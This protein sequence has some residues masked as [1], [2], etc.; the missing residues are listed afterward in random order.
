M[1]IIISIRFFEDV[2]FTYVAENCIAIAIN[3]VND[4]SSARESFAVYWISFKW[5]TFAFICIVIAQTL[6]KFFVIC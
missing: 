1:F 3:T 6:K 5:K 4:K 2:A